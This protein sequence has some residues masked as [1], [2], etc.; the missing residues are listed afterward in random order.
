M[1]AVFVF[2]GDLMCLVPQNKASRMRDGS[3]NYDRIFT[4]VSSSLED[5]D[6]VIGNLETPLAG[7]ELGYTFEQTVFNTPKEFAISA[8]NSGID[9]FTLANNHILDRGIIGLKNTVANIKS[10]GADYIGAYQNLVEANS[11]LIKE[12]DGIKVAILSFTYGTNSEWRNNALDDS[13]DYSVDLLRKQDPYNGIKVDPVKAKIKNV[14]KSILPQSI[15]EKIRPIV[16]EDCVEGNLQV[17]GDEK[18]ILRLKEKIRKAKESSDYVVMC[19]HSGGQYNSQIGSYTRDIAHKIIDCGCDLI[20]GN[21]PHC[22]LEYEIYKDKLITYSLGN[23]CFTP[24]WGFYY[25]GVYADYSL[26]LKL[27]LQRDEKG[28]LK[29]R[30]GIIPLKCVKERDGNSVVYPIRTLINQY[31]EKIKKKTYDDV[32]KVIRRFLKR[33]I[34]VKDLSMTSEI[35]ITNYLI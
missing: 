34:D 28:L 16:S 11:I 20:I 29:Q 13:T 33:D 22:V 26:L 31:G 30:I 35:D 3:Y 25:K 14:I 15:R 10:I 27:Y 4:Y 2:T 21:H 12:F 17:I 7:R 8:Y 32:K 9:C 5:A 19:M 1:A 18:Y 24:N 6:Y 23:F